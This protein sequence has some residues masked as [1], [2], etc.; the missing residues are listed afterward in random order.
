MDRL[1]PLAVCIKE[2][3]AG[4]SSSTQNNEG[5]GDTAATTLKQKQPLE[6]SAERTPG[7]TAHPTR[8]WMHGTVV[9][10]ARGNGFNKLTQQEAVLCSLGRDPR[11]ALSGPSAP[12][13]AG[14][15]GTVG[16]G[17]QSRGG[18]SLGPG[19][20]GGF[21]D[22]TPQPTQRLTHTFTDHTFTGHTFTGHTST[23]HTF[24][25]HTSTGHTST[26]HTFTGHTSTGHTSTG[27]TS[28]GHTF[29]GHTSTGHTF[30]GH[31]STGHTS[32][33]HTFT[34]HTSTGHTSTDHT[35]TDHTLHASE[36]FD[37][38]GVWE[39]KPLTTLVIRPCQLV[40]YTPATPPRGVTA[41]HEP[42]GPPGTPG[43]PGSGPRAA[44]SLERLRG[45]HVKLY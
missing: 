37:I 11:R 19:S 39:L 43:T 35:F 30:T 41:P 26:D 6:R 25:G 14:V 13:L 15:Q 32:T 34:G 10:L 33:D 44:G 20:R 7:D 22:R 23:G 29:T 1:K 12:R 5:G 17:L 4:W 9:C 18:G 40:N 28:T 2:I 27:H 3:T 45:S 21:N 16:L 42:P 24:T 36:C 8:S 31:T 38:S